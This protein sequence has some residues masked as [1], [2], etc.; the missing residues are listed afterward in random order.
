MKKLRCQELLLELVLRSNLGSFAKPYFKILITGSNLE[1]MASS[2]NIT[3]F[4][5]IRL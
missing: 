5:A 4:S 2:I 3:H 1:I